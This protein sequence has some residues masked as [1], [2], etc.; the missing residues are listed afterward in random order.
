MARRVGTVGPS[1]EDQTLLLSL[2]TAALS[3]VSRSG[4]QAK[5]DGQSLCLQPYLTKQRS[6]DFSKSLALFTPI[7]CFYSTTLV[8]F[9]LVVWP[10]LAA[11]I[12][13]FSSLFVSC[14]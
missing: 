4:V 3:G 1:I 10:Y 9:K 7:S 2:Q 6:A 11:A 5:V 8:V 12:F 14:L 13:C